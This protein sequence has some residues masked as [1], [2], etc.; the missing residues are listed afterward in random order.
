VASDIPQSLVAPLSV[1]ASIAALQGDIHGALRIGEE[2]IAM[3]RS[4]EDSSIASRTGCVFALTLLDIGQPERARLELLE[5]AGG[6]DLPL[7]TS[8]LRWAAFEGLTRAEIAL[9]NV[10]RAEEWAG[11]A[12]RASH[13]AIPLSKAIACRARA[14]VLLASGDVEEAANEAHS[15]GSIQDG[16]GERIEASRSRILAGRALALAGKVSEATDVLDLAVNTLERAGAMRLRDE[17]S[18]ELRR[19]GRRVPRPA[20]PIGARG[21]SAA[22]SS[23]SPTWSVRGR[24]TARSLPTFS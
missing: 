17:A 5:A 15:A 4:M 19:L 18:H 12:D 20:Q 3:A 24:P 10:S 22:A 2:S 13:R 7:I 16:L 11:R 21:P 23:R 9:G 6:P 1:E 14:A 8:G